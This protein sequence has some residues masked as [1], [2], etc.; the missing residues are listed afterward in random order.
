MRFVIIIATGIVMFGMVS[1]QQQVPNGGLEAWTLVPGSGSFKDYEEPNDGWTSGNGVIHVAPG[2]DP[3]CEKTT[4]AHTGQYAAKLTTRSI[5]GQMASGSMF[6]GV[7][8][9]NLANPVS[10]ARRGIPFA[11]PVPSRFR[12]FYRYQPVGTDSGAI[13]AMFTRW[14][15]SARVVIHEA[16]LSITASTSNWTEFDIAVPLFDET[17]DSMSVV[18]AS[19]ADGENFKG[20]VGST[21]WVDDLSFS[22]STSDV[23][24]STTAETIIVAGSVAT[25][26]NAER[27]RSV[28]AVDLLG[29][30]INLGQI[31][32]NGQVD[33]SQCTGG[34]WFLTARDLNGALVARSLGVYIP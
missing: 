18:A 7:F 11:G 17:P 24:E 16:R 22:W 23:Q 33:L 12:G 31:S 9:L 21:L 6:L 25:I 32:S 26:P 2:S 8:K 14:N 30:S 15:G 20:S 1:A 10:S 13:Y 4:D 34:M 27:V 19:S 3:V 29:R 28:H 5:F